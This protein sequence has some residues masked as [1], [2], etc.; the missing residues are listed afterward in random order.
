MPSKW[1]WM[2]DAVYMNN[3]N[4]SRKK[5]LLLNNK[6]DILFIGI[7]V[8]LSFFF[9]TN[10]SL[11]PWV[12]GDIRRDS[13]VFKTVALMIEKG[14]MPYKH[15]F[16]H[17]GPVIYLLNYIGNM[18]AAY[19]GVWFIEYASLFITISINYYALRRLFKTSA[20]FSSIAVFTGLSLLF[21][22]FQ[23]GNLTEEYAMPFISIGNY[24][25]LNYLMNNKYTPFSLCVCGFSFGVVLMLRVN[26][27]VMW[28]VYCL[29]ILFMLIVNKRFKELLSCSAWFF[30][31][32]CIVIVP[33]MIWLWINDALKDF[34]FDYIQFNLIYSSAEGGRA[35]NVARWD[36][37]YHFFKTPVYTIA[38]LSSLFLAFK[39]KRSLWTIYT[40]VLIANLLLI[41]ISGMQ[42]DHYGMILIPIVIIPIGGMLS[43]M[44]TSSKD[45]PIGGYLLAGFLLCTVIWND[46]SSNINAA[47]KVY[48]NRLENHISDNMMTMVDLIKTNTDSE[49][50]ISVY[51]NKDIVYVMSQRQH[52]TKYSYQYPIG[53]VCPEIME[54][55]WRELQAEQ[56]KI[57][58]V[59]KTFY[60]DT[61]IDFL[62]NNHYELLWAENSDSLLDS[63]SLFI[64]SDSIE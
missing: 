56:P 58:V 4:T 7:F 62:E 3:S 63:D 45:Q 48:A 2:E 15:S 11:H 19:N 25:F 27:V 12:K 60:Y 51:G 35:T 14:Y 33:I 44:S 43:F 41:C 30:I 21:A 61:I 26:M 40:I 39:S 49:D 6:L 47:G 18:I 31:G 36:S 55:Y 23:G 1:I 52:A 32:A 54:D 38:L 16:D 9:L 37:F 50:T 34:W 64:K 10:S 59:E 17:K 28:A 29:V 20:A 8:I 13:S 42:Y 57:I 24:V 53:V 22:Y 46:W 5:E